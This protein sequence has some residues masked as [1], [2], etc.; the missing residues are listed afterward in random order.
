[1]PVESSISCSPM[2]NRYIHNVILVYRAD[3]DARVGSYQIYSTGHSRVGEMPRQNS[4][5]IC[6]D[7]TPD[8]SFRALRRGVSK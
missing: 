4:L 6:T 1:M 7:W 5:R 3:S 2:P 8:A